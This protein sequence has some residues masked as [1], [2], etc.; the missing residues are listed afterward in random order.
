MGDATVNGD[1]PP[2]ATIDVGSDLFQCVIYML[3]D[4]AC[5]KISY[6]QGL[7][8]HLQKLPHWPVFD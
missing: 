6:G 2:S 8:R 4:L 1:F 3:I 5:H 7:D